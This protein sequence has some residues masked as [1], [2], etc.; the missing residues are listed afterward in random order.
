M[1]ISAMT[2]NGLPPLTIVQNGAGTLVS[3]P[4]STNTQPDGTQYSDFSPMGPPIVDSDGS[5]YVEYEVRQIA[6]PPRITSAVLYL[7]KIAEDG[8]RTTTVVSA[9]IDDEN[10]LPGRII[11]DG[12]GGVLA[13]WTI[14]PSSG[15]APPRPYQAAHV[16]SGSVAL[17]YDLPFSTQTVALGTYPTLVLGENGTA[18]ATDGINVGALTQS[19]GPQ[20]VSFNLASGSVN[21]QYQTTTQ[22]SLTILAVTSDG[23]IAINDSQNGV[24]QL[25]LNGNAT[26]VTAALG[27]N[28]QYSWGGNWFAQG[29]QAA[30]KLLLPLDVDPGDEWATP[31]GNPATNGVPDSLCPCLLQSVSGG[32]SSPSATRSAHSGLAQ[33][34]AL[35]EV[36]FAPAASGPPPAD[37]PFCGLTA[38]QC[39]TPMAG[40]LSTYLIIIGDEGRNNGPGHNWDMG[41]T[42]PLAAQQQANDLNFQGHRVMACRASTVQDL[43]NALTTNGPIDGGVIYYG[44]AGRITVSGIQYSALFVGQDPLVNENVYAG[45]VNVLSGAQLGP[46]ASVWLNGCD[47]AVD[48]Q[49][50]SSIAQL[51]SNQLNRGVYA[52]DVGVYFSS[53]TIA[54]DPYTSGNGRKAPADLPVY[55]VPVGAPHQKPNYKPF[56]PYVQH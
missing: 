44:H 10:L 13:T 30:S 15:P 36:P 4:T 2:N 50:G 3:I 25:D 18:F 24:I 51:I 35:V 42:F 53:Y 39:S 28:P 33:T 21:W 46:D 45:N 9:T 38:P 22:S 47:T 6:Y 20:V 17:V 32:S 41:Y 8:S 19:D 14:A 11:P 16:V 52:Y 54:N 31:N 55:A 48:A 49:G 56:T 27:G 23:G 5:A 7:L 26:L 34:G 12:Q 43:N 29:P 40:T 1:I 37:C